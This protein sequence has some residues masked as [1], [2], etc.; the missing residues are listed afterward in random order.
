[1]TIGTFAPGTQRVPALILPAGT[2][3]WVEALVRNRRANGT[4]SFATSEP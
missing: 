1:M 3:I 4:D 2:F